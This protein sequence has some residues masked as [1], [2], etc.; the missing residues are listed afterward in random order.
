MKNKVLLGNTIMM[1]IL[2]IAKL[3]I[4]LVSLP[5]LT[6]V[7]SV[8]CYG[9]VSFVKSIITYLQIIVDFGFLLSGTKDLIKTLD[10]KEE[11]SKK[12]GN[13]LYAQ[14][15]LCLLSIVIMLI[16]VLCFDILKGYEL[17]AILSLVTV[18]LT[19]FLFEYVFKAYEQ[20]GKIAIRYV[21]MKVVALILTLIFVKGDKDIYLIPIFD[22][23]SSII[24]IIMVVFQIKKLGVKCEFSFRRI[25]E[26]LNSLKDSFIY[27]ISNA[28]TTAFTA[29]NTLI[30]GFALTK[31]DIAYWSV[32]MQLVGVVQTLYNPIISSV[33]PTMV[34]EKDL[35]IIHK[36]MLIYMP[37]ILIGCICIMLFGDWAIGLVFTE[38]YLM[39]STLLK[40]LIPLLILSFPAMLYGWPCL[41]AIDKQKATSFSTIVS[42]LVQVCGLIL[43]LIID[44]F[45]LLNICIVRCVTELCLCSI[46]MFIVYKNK[47][48]F[49]RVIVVNNDN[50]EN[51]EDFVN[52]E[53]KKENI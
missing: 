21:L 53:N 29:L 33:F 17:Y 40:Y 49:E 19:V 20:M 10:N 25:K 11:T 35:K 28:A 48:L 2:S 12:I 42:S 26:A 32:T 41:G 14:L 38:K 45:T 37:V 30:I 6:R 9:S 34:K 8:D 7:L 43:L 51:V 13:T 5:Y 18:I 52:N 46:R 27:F 39:S 47:N 50:N 3:V 23:I 4:P 44:Q 1:Y 15:L 16:C 22:I 24:A 31:S 36:I